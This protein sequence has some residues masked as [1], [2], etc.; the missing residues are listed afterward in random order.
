MVTKV[1]EILKQ[2]NV[3]LDITEEMLNIEI[4]DDNFQSYHTEMDRNMKTH[5]FIKKF[6]CLGSIATRKVTIN[7]EKQIV[8]SEIDTG[9]HV[10]NIVTYYNKYGKI[11]GF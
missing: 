9:N 11:C 10:K 2:F 6:R 3:E 8:I 1:K 4:N 5:I 7:P